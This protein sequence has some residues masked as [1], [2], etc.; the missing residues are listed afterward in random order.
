MSDLRYT[1]EVILFALA[2]RKTMTGEQTAKAVSK[3]FGFACTRPA[4]Y[5][6]ISMYRNGQRPVGQM[7]GSKPHCQ[8]RAQTLRARGWM[9]VSQMCDRMGIDGNVADR[10]VAALPPPC[11][12]VNGL[13][14][15]SP[16][17]CR[18][19]MINDPTVRFNTWARDFVVGVYAAS[20][21]VSRKN[22]KK[23]AL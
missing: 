19:L 7:R 6:H 4:I 13:R 8:P 16:G 21:R 1:E 3:R 23:A 11:R 20:P 18:E 10:F 2:C 15:Y 14:L 12:V 17:V 5:Y 22:V 9:T